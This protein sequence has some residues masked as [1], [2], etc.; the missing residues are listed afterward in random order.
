MIPAPPKADARLLHALAQLAPCMNSPIPVVAAVI[1][2]NGL[3]LVAQRP[4]NK[5]LALK[6]EFPGGKMEE[7]ENPE[8]A[9]KREIR[10]EL[11]CEIEVTGRLKRFVFRYEKVSID[12]I[13]LRARLIPGTPEPVAHEHVALQWLPVTKLS[14]LDL[15]AADIPVLEELLR[16]MR[17]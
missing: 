4:A 1:E 13:P 8:T 9:L 2:R 12:L 6:W 3:V 5:L 7:G 14:D 10:E 11:G 17:G 16:K 15:A